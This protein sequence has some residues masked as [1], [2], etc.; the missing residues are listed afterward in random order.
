MIKN[1]LKLTWRNLVQNKVS[2]AINIGG[3]AIGLACVILIG[4]YVKDEVNY[5]RFFADAGRIYRV[6]THEKLGSDE[7]TAGNTPPPAGKALLD[8]FPEV[9]S[10]TRLYNPGNQVVHYM[11]DGHNNAITERHLLA[12]DSNFLRF[13]EYPLQEGDRASCLDKPNSIVLTQIAA[14]RYFGDQSA[15]GKTLVFDQYKAPFVV[16]AVLRDLPTQSSLQF[17]ILLPT[18]AM[19]AVKRFSWSW[20]W[21][22]MGTYVK[23]RSGLPNTPAALR[24]IEAG[25][26]AMV[27]VQAASAFS[28]VGQPIEEFL[29]KG[30]RY[31]LRL[32]PLTAV[33]LYSADIGNPFFP[34]G[35]V[36]YVYIFSAIALFIILLACVNFMNLAT[37]QSARRARE[38]GIRKVL[39]S[40]RRQLIGQFL[41]EAF[42]FTVIAAVVAVGLASIALPAFNSLSG[43]S[44]N[45]AAFFDIS[46]IAGLLVLVLLT[47]ALAGSYPAIYLTS[48]SPAAMMKGS[49]GGKNPAGGFFTR[50]ALVV[51]QFTVSMVLI[52]CTV[53]VY[54]QLLF[55]QSKDLGFDKGNVLVISGAKRLGN[56]E[57]AFRQELL[58]LPGVSGATISTG[59]PAMNGS[60]QD[61]YIPQEAGNSPTAGDRRED[62]ISFIVDDEFLPTMK[63]EMAGGRNFSRTYSDSASVILNESAAKLMGWKDPIG[64]HIVYP[65]GN[66]T[67]FTVIGMVKD[68]HFESLHTPIG[69]FV[70]FYPTSK[71][72]NT[73]VSYIAVRLRAGD[74]AKTI[75]SVQRL[76]KRFEPENPF[77]YSFLDA[78][79]DSL[80][81]TDVTIGKVFG[82]FTLLSLAVACLGLLGLALYTAER[83]TKEI[84]IRKVLGASVQHV[85]GMLSKEFLKLVGLAALIAIPIAWYAMY[86]WLQ[87]FAYPTTL[88]WW[89]FALTAAITTT[90]ALATIS[91][92]SIKAGLANPVNSLRSE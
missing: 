19:P 84:G 52:N 1:Y 38:V 40:E 36:K 45:L 89:I 28:R 7:F 22:Q 20:V 9:E 51:F 42:A 54:K 85:A 76:W 55:E 2:S 72:Y 47:A 6:N 66:D 44:L 41:G 8:Q 82:V 31:D 62:L 59:L 57:E 34:Q 53:I 80:Y 67:R 87:D 58:R 13:F 18:Q 74:P 15:L 27:R 33:H 75:A 61:T 70:L 78:E 90:I 79:Y 3:L 91:F 24:R 69:P 73:G 14:R 92:Q 43:K 71:T 63:M 48:F 88:D 35:D 83:R 65:G 77:D 17:D 49:L 4:I 32:Q 26:P 10:Y 56:N 86:K 25:I 39:G 21:L 81:K 11:S 29:K 23:L 64:K 5:D 37:A 50:N 30:N 12:V 60:F 16:T 68:F 46:G